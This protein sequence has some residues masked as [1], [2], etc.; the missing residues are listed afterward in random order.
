MKH[1]TTSEG[2]LALRLTHHSTCYSSRAFFSPATVVSSL[3]ALPR[4]SPELRHLAIH[5][6]VL[7][8]WLVASVVVL[9]TAT[10]IG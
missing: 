1:T 4:S 10:S 6:P 8:S 2:L 9:L 7:H 5:T 3:H